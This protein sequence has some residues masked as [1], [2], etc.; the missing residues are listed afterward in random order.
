MQEETELQQQKLWE[1]LAGYKEQS[2]QHSLTIVALEDRLQEAKEQ[3]KTL[4]EENAALVAKMEG[5]YGWC[6]M[7]LHW[8]PSWGRLYRDGVGQWLLW[9]VLCKMLV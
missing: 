1:E 9:E 2:K 4:E 7:S 8:E 5:S 3:Q 6:G